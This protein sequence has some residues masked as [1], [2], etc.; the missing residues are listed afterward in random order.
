MIVAQ[1]LLVLPIIAALTRQT[2]EDLWVEYRDE[3][4]AMRVGPLGRVTTLIWDARFSLV[5]ALLAGFGRAAA[6]VGTVMIVGGNIDGFT[7]TMTT[8]IAL[9]TSKGD[10][11]LA[12]RARRGAD[13]HRHRRQCA[14][15]G[16]AACRRDARRDDAMHGPASDLPIVL[17]SVT[18]R[19][20]D[21]T[22]LDR[23]SLAIG[24]GAPTVLIGPNG[25]GKSTL[26]R[27]AM[28]LLAPNAGSILW[29]GRSQDSGE[30]R[31][32]M[33]QRPVMLRRSAAANVAYALKSRP[34]QRRSRLGACPRCCAGR[35]RWLRRAAGAPPVGRR[36]AAAGAGPRARARAGGAVPR[37]ADREP[38]SGLDQ[39]GRGHHPARSP[40]RGVKIV[41]ATHDLGQA[42]RLAGE[43]VFLVRGRMV[44]HAAPS[45]FFANP[46]TPE[47]AAF[48]RGDLVI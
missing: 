34:A 12:H 31:A 7:R 42:R 2:I 43:I 6:E 47:A 32:M 39:G 13:R 24:P 33:F 40:R 26:I 17:D 20:G 29:G 16:R 11:P 41:M 44:E 38:R 27:L 25:S 8:A 37:R 35:P 18:L 3:L 14:R 5:T 23:V 21:V 1:A 30:R 36:A 45:E 19:A 9:E 22:M 10:L 48:L 15:L 4:T 46:A 28:G